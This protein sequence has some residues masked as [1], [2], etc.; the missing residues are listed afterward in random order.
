MGLILGLKAKPSAKPTPNVFFI[1]SLM[2]VGG[3]KKNKIVRH[4]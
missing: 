4:F 1:E 3:K 2:G